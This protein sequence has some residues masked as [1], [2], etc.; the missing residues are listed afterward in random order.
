MFYYIDHA[1]DGGH[2][3]EECYGSAWNRV[4]TTREDADEE[5]VELRFEADDLEASTGDDRWPSDGYSVEPIDRCPDGWSVVG[6][7]AMS[8]RVVTHGIDVAY[9]R[10]KCFGPVY[11]FHMNLRPDEN[12]VQL[13]RRAVRNVL[14]LRR[15]GFPEAYIARPTA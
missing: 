12:R 11:T 13:L 5:C 1:E 2:R 3:S 6:E 9:Y 15:V 8:T 4:Y 14:R 10:E 7:G